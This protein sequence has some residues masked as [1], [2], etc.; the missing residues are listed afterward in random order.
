M[1][2]DAG[3]TRHTINR[4]AETN[5]AYRR[6]PRIGTARVQPRRGELAATIDVMGWQER[7]EWMS[8]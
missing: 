1:A 4:R 5:W 7:K 8:L 3:Q 6:N 2:P